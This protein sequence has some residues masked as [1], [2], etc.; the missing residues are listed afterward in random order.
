MAKRNGPGP[1]SEAIPNETTTTS[2]HHE[3]GGHSNHTAVPGHQRWRN[4]VRR[5]PRLD[6]GCSQPC[7]CSHKS[8]PTDRRVAGYREAIA[9][10][11]AAGLTA[12]PLLPELR[13]LWRAGDRQ[14]VAAVTTRW[15]VSTDA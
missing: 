15:E 3:A 4:Q 5:M 1:K 9:H 7:R 13:R 12:A 10:L 8:H 2:H 14:L 11:D 6:C